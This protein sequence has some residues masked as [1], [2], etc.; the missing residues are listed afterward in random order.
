MQNLQNKKILVFSVQHSEIAASLFEL[1]SLL[2]GLLPKLKRDVSTSLSG[3]KLTKLYA[4]NQKSG[5]ARLNVDL[6][7]D[8]HRTKVIKAVSHST[9]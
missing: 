6:N 1:T 3:N 2:A 8:Y 7:A 4:A 9:Q 5:S